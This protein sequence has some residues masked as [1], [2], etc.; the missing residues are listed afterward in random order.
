[1]AVLA[2]FLISTGLPWAKFWGS[3][4]KDVRAITGTLD[5]PQD[6]PTGARNA[7]LGDHATIVRA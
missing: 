5:G 6:W 1:M 2:L 3:Y 4:F 7:M